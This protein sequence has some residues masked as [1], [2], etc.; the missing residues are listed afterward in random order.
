MHF[1]WC[2]SAFVLSNENNI[3]DL[4]DNIPGK[5]LT[6]KSGTTCWTSSV[7]GS[8]LLT[9]GTSGTPNSSHF[10][11]AFYYIATV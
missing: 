9:T 6:G 3:R 2:C 5:R 11:I 8:T 4:G 7:S 1:V 10:L